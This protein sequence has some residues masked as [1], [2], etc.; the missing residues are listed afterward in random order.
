M[1]DRQRLTFLALNIVAAIA[2]GVL[3]YFVHEQGQTIQAERRASVLRNCHD[4]NQ[5]HWNTIATLDE[6]IAQAPP[7]RRAQ[8]AASRRYTVL[9]IQALAPLQDCDALV[10]RAVSGA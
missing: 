6:L 3:F 1:S 2:M 9:L 8:A 10:K 4:Q 7:A 5:R